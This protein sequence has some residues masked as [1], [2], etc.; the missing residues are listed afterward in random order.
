MLALVPKLRAFALSL[1]HDANHADD[2]VQETI[3][4]AWA[5]L[6][7][8]EPGTNMKA[9]LFVILRNCVLKGHRKRR[10]W[11]DDPD[12]LY[13]ERLQTAP[14]QHLRLDVQDMLKALEKLRPERREV[15]I[16]TAAE[17]LSYE[18]AARICGVPE[19]T[20]KSRLARARTH[21]ARLLTIEG[22]EDLGPDRVMQAALQGAIWEP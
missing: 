19:G 15:L 10:P 17:G 4:R 5:A 7:R 1:T 3:L 13:A 16:L 18:E 20:V 21:L 22:A 6:D 14:D 2:L 8:F 12:G 11:I 9:W